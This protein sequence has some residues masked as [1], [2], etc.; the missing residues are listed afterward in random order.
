ML[1][2]GAEPRVFPHTA[3]ASDEEVRKRLFAFFRSGEGAMVWDNILGVFDTASFAAALTSKSYSDRVLGRSVNE[4]VP[5]RAMMLL[6]GNNLSLK[7]DMARRVLVCRIDPRQERP[8]MRSFD[9][10]P[11]AYTEKYRTDLVLDCLTI[12]RCWLISGSTPEGGRFASFEAWD[13]W[14]RQAV[15]WIGRD[16]V[17]GACCDPVAALGRADGSN[18]DLEMLGDLLSGLFSIFQEKIFTAK[19]VT[20]YARE[21]GLHLARRLAREAGTN[22]M[23]P[24]DLGDLLEQYSPKALAS[25]RSLGRIFSNQKDKIVDGLVLRAQKDAQKNQMAW[26]IE[27]MT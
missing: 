2:T 17:P 23:C 22:Q 5:S 13:A 10:C 3:D 1:A 4:T 25:P 20:T 9:F 26:R 24:K 18:P 27:R 15:I 11:L 21:Q 8:H 14:V 19:D 7:G 6:T 16:V 12:L